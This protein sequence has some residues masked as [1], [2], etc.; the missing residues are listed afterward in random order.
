[1][2]L[3]STMQGWFKQDKTYITFVYDFP[4]KKKKKN[5]KNGEIFQVCCLIHFSDAIG[6]TVVQKYLIVLIYLSF[7]KCQKFCETHF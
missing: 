6:L 5:P 4:P 2:I 7:L 1:M 3:T